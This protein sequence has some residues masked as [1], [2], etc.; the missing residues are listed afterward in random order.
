MFV[1]CTSSELMFILVYMNN[2]IFIGSNVTYLHYF[3]IALHTK[4][5]LKDLNALY[6]FL[7]LQVTINNDDLHLCQAKYITN[8]L[9]CFDIKHSKL[10]M[11][12]MTLRE[13]LIKLDGNL[14]KDLST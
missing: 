4:F 12:L 2:I 6:F 11:S 14:L 3:V 10:A 13:I 8:L 7:G 1:K 5:V 9:Y